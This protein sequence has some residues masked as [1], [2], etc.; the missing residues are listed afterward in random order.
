MQFYNFLSCIFDEGNNF[1]GLNKRERNLHYSNNNARFRNCMISELFT[2]NFLI[3]R[4]NYKFKC[5][6]KKP[7]FITFKVSSYTNFILIS[8]QRPHSSFIY[9]M[10]FVH[11]DSVH[12]YVKYILMAFMK[13]IKNNMIN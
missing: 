12:A 7:F 9:K 8:F 5:V 13:N 1:S 2:F 3:F 4:H 6:S 11:Q 10:V